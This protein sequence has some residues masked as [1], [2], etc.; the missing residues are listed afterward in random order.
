MGSGQECTSHQNTPTKLFLKRLAAPE[1]QA[2]NNQCDGKKHKNRLEEPGFL[3]FVFAVKSPGPP[4]PADARRIEWRE[5]GS[6]L[7]GGQAL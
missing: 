5:C 2:A 7:S 6:L 4:V 1:T 3:F